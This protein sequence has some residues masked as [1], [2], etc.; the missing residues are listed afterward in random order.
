[1]KIIILD[2][3]KIHRTGRVDTNLYIHTDTL[4]QNTIF[5]S[6]STFF[7]TKQRVALKII[8]SVRLTEKK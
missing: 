8:I 2:P 7:S 5:P 4:R 6:G 1:M 3:N